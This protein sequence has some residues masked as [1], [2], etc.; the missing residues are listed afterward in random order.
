MGKR[1]KSR[2]QRTFCIVAFL[3]GI[4]LLIALL[5]SKHRSNEESV[6]SDRII[7]L[8]SNRFHLYQKAIVLF[9]E[10]TE[11]VQHLEVVKSTQLMLQKKRDIAFVR[12]LQE[13]VDRDLDKQAPRNARNPE[14]DDRPNQSVSVP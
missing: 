3:A 12:F 14:T 5:H 1:T 8:Y 10:N 9:Q 13:T 4:A 2:R 7:T 11:P 6:S